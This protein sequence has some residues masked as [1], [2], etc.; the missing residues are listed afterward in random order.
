MADTEEL[1]SSLPQESPPP[2]IVLSAVRG[3]RYRAIATVSSLLLAAL[4]IFVVLPSLATKDLGV[5]A[6]GLHIREVTPLFVSG[7]AAD[8]KVT[9]TELIMGSGEGYV[10]FIIEELGDGVAE[11][12]FSNVLIS[13]TGEGVFAAESSEGQSFE[14]GFVDSATA[15][16]YADVPDA[17]SGWLRF[18]GD[19]DPNGPLSVL[20]DVFLV[21]PEAFET[22]AFEGTPVQL[23][24]DYPGATR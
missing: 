8:V 11:V 10:H 17:V 20:F 1:L 14:V 23:R 4:L 15:T 3:F 21:P 19:H 24:I 13:P 16:Y 2:E 5:R 22:G 12:S 9:L 7:Q 18:E 6:E